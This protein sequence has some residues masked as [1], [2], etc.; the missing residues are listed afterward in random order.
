MMPIM[1]GEELLKL[2]KADEAM[3]DIP[4]VMM[5]AAGLEWLSQD[6]RPLIAGF[7]QKPFTYDQLRAALQAALPAS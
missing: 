1:S 2:L 7:L 3:R 6:L 4:V 5:S